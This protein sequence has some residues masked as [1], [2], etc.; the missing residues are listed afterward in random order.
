MTSRTKIYIAAFGKQDAT[1]FV[2][3]YENLKAPASR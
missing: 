2:F 1:D 3:S